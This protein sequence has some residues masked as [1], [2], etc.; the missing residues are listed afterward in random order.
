MA[1]PEL[2]LT[3]VL[4]EIIVKKMLL[5]RAKLPSGIRSKYIA[6]KA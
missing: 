4:N 1:N 2:F 3:D 5:I 6:I